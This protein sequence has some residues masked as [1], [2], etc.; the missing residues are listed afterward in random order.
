M[1]Q[2]FEY[3]DTQKVLNYNRCFNFIEG[4]RNQ[5]KT[6]SSTKAALK[7][8]I[9]K[10]KQFALIR[11]YEVDLK[12]TTQFFLNDMHQV[13]PD[14]DL[15]FIKG[16]FYIDGVLAGH[17]FA[18]SQML[19]LKSIPLPDLQLCIFDEYLPEDGKYITGKNGVPEPEILLNFFQTVAR[20]YNQPI[21]NDI[22]FVF[23]SNNVSH[24]NPYFK[25]FN[26]AKHMKDD[27][28]MVKGE[29]WLY[30][31]VQDKGIASL[32][33]DTAFGRFIKDTPYGRYAIDNESYFD[34]DFFI[35]KLPENTRYMCSLKHSNKMY[36]LYVDEYTGIY[37]LTG[38]ALENC[39]QIF[40]LDDYSHNEETQKDIMEFIKQLKQS[41]NLGLLRFESIAE[42]YMFKEALKID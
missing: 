8:C 7:K 15:Q 1:K 34:N 6:F 22:Q 40:S 3:F 42:K 39:R 2:N 29:F 23:L 41:Y 37:Y 19:K 36:G 16:K 30:Y 27:T 38:K 24:D 9:N 14:H 32:L 4:G 28:K 12:L 5:G 20:G 33:K 11:R 21:R 31:K 10:G 17:Q 35:K 13:F 26:I 18:V 25:Y